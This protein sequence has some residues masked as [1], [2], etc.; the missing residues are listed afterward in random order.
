M[1][2]AMVGRDSRG[3]SASVMRVSARPPELAGRNAKGPRVPIDQETLEQ[4]EAIL[5]HT[6]KDKDLVEIALTHA[7]IADHRLISNERLEFLGDAVLGMLVCDYLYAT[8][9][10]LLEGD[11]TKIKSAAVSRRMC[12]TIAKSLGLQ[13][14]LLLGKGMKTRSALPSSLSAAVLES[15]VGALYLDGGLETAREFLMPLLMPH[16]DRAA[17]SG[18][19]QNFKSVLQQHAQREMGVSPN[20]VLVDEKGPDHA[21]AFAVCVELEGERYDPCWAPSKKLAEQHAALS[22]LESMGLIERDDDGQILYVPFDGDDTIDASD[23]ED[24]TEPSFTD[25]DDHLVRDEA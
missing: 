15:A 8:Y 6:F 20:Y 9:P 19:Q 10:D 5:G 24:E 11:L 1:C 13:D 7:S 21:K 4:T 2:I 3:R 25:G 12:A 18:H 23:D 14:L 16:I 22:A 17:Q